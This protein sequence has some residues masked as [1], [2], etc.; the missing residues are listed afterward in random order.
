MV[1]AVAMLLIGLQLIE[2]FP[3]IS[4]FKLTLPPALGK[5]FGIHQ[6]HTKEYRHR[7]AM[8][9]GALT[10][11]LP[12]GFTQ[13]MQL[14]AIT[15][16]GFL[17]GASIMAAFA[18]GTLP[19]LLGIGGLT[20]IVRGNS[21]KIFFKTAGLL[22]ISFA[23]FNFANGYRLTG[24]EPFWE[25]SA[26][27]ATEVPLDTVPAVSDGDVQV[28]EMVQKAN[29]YTPNTFTIKQ[30]VPVR[31]VITS[32]AANSCAASISMPAYGITKY[33]K[34]GENIIEFTPEETG[35]IRFSCS[36]GMY[37]GKFNVVK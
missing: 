33:L 3:K 29:G 8:I 23:F 31:W 25:V 24:P 13:M 9:V 20:S 17:S 4:G 35:T 14:N 10:F 6:H 37:T 22:V 15:S 28:I 11:F 19:G 26:P 21:A 27:P 30:G 32:E 12:C 16:G 2:I 36:M 1:V 18:V 34:A 5:M 7:G